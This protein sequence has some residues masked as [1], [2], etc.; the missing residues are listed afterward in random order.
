MPGSVLLVL[1]EVDERAALL[2]RELVD[3]AAG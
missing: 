2:A 1:G 3:A